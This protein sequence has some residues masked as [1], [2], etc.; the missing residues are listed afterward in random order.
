MLSS[1]ERE[2]A[3]V[4][5][6]S[7]PERRAEPVKVTRSWALL[8]KYRVSYCVGWDVKSLVAEGGTNRLMAPKL[9]SLCCPR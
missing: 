8:K 9:M 4:E 3:C 2:V 1:S 6:G 5:V 7:R